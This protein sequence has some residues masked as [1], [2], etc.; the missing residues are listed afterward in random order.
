[1]CLPPGPVGAPRREGSTALL[2]LPPVP[3]TRDT[4]AFVGRD[5]V[6]GRSLHRPGALRPASGDRL[7]DRASVFRHRSSCLQPAS[8]RTSGQIRSVD[9]QRRSVLHRNDSN[10]TRPTAA[11]FCA[12]QPAS[13]PDPFSPWSSMG[14]Q[15]SWTERRLM[16]DR[17]SA[18]GC[19]NAE[20][21]L[22]L[23]AL[24]PFRLFCLCGFKI[25]KQSMLRITIR[26]FFVFLF[27]LEVTDEVRLPT[28]R[29]G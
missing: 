16:G 20:A 23:A 14:L 25:T 6:P 3:C 19:C 12:S 15:S 26:R 27:K 13:Q 17:C 10:S 9:W 7:T 1:L 2:P 5:N 22:W 24:I 4:A 11:D 21:E 28:P 18:D 8:P 29:W